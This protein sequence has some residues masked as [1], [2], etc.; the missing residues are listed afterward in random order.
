MSSSGNFFKLCLRLIYIYI[1]KILKAETE[2]KF[3]CRFAILCSP[4]A[5]SLNV[6][7]SRIRSSALCI[8]R[9]VS[10]VQHFL[11]LKKVRLMFT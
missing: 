8:F 4:S 2:K 10:W 7:Q 11:A 3:S 9:Q 5:L 6:C 1:L